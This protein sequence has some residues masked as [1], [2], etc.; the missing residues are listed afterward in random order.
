[1][2]GINNSTA[3]YYVK[4]MAIIFLV[5]LINAKFMA[6]KKPP[7]WAVIVKGLFMRD[8][9][10]GKLQ[11]ALNPLIAIERQSFEQSHRICLLSHPEKAC[12]QAMPQKSGGFL[13]KVLGRL[14]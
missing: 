3:I 11:V 7:Q 4:S 14:F 10:K 6:Q 9:I 8:K 1:M 13:S 2:H 12:G 5:Y